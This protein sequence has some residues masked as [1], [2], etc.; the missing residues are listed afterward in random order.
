[1]ST[2]NFLVSLN[3]TESYEGG[4]ANDPHDPGGATM[5]GV[6]QAV[7]TAWLARHGRADTAV[8]LIP[9]AD[10]QA[11]Y[12]EGYW[13]PVRG[14]DLYD[15]LDLVMVDTAWGSGSDRAIRLLQQVLGVTIDGKFGPITLAAVKA[16]WN[17]T[18]LINQL[19]AA[20]MAFFQSLSTWKY[21]GVG[22]THRLNG[23]QAQALKMNALSRTPPGDRPMTEATV[24]TS[25]ATVATPARVVPAITQA[26]RI[27]WIDWL[28]QFAA[29][30]EPIAVS[31]VQLGI[32]LGTDQIPVIGPMIYASLGPMVA[33]DAV[34]AAIKLT[35]GALDALKG[36]AD[37]ITSGNVILTTA[38]SI[39]NST[40]PTFAAK[41][42]A[43]VDGW[44]S[45]ALAAIKP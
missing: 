34:D 24:N 40:A 12:R 11:I 16:H 20:R 28:E 37:T 7:Y 19:C 23:I 13:N 35:T 3:E 14:D 45:E 41:A 31:V 30:E 1:M 6:T 15:G 2:L 10:I 18:E 33:K 21:F 4:Y 43:L 29:H 32:K 44:L 25:P 9:D 39:I 36:S 17:S 27:P 5:K 8:R 26:T 22:W 42:G 38:A